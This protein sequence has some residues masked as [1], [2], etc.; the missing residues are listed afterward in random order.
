[1]RSHDGACLAR[2]PCRCHCSPTPRPLEPGYRRVLV[3]P[4]PGGGLTSAS[5]RLAIPHGEVSVDRRVQGETLTV[6]TTLP[7]GVS[8]LFSQPG[9]GDVVE[10]GAGTHAFCVGGLRDLVAKPQQ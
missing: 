4:R 2:P 3:A 10:L 9:E 7:D 1:M 5:T 8:G 6:R